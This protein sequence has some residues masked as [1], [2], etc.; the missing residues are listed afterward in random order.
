MS[1]RMVVWVSQLAGTQACDV[2]EQ[3]LSQFDVRTTSIQE[4]I[5]SLISSHPCSGVFFDFDYPDRRRLEMFA[6]AI[7]R[8]PSLPFIMVTLQHSESLAIWSFRTGVMDY[9]VKPLQNSDIAR[10]IDCLQLDIHPHLQRRSRQPPSFM[11]IPIPD[12]IPN[13]PSS[14]KQLLA[15]AVAYVRRNYSRR[16]VSDGMARLCGMSSSQFGRAFRHVYDMTF[17]EFVVRYRVFQAFIALQAPGANISEIA[18]SVGFSDP[19]YF[20]RVFKRYVG[21]APSELST[22]SARDIEG[23]LGRRMIA[24]DD[25]STSQLVRSLSSSFMS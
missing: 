7:A 3:V 13:M 9:L 18:Y 22:V 12:T 8:F 15:P 23:I 24:S 19:S 1:K 11:Q 20:T 14:K 6:A 10:C 16:I 4:D 17:Q 5:D 25:S 2:P 21:V